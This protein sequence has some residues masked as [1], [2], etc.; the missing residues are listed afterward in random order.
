[1]RR[2]GW[3]RDEKKWKVKKWKEKAWSEEDKKCLTQRNLGE[4][5]KQKAK[6]NP[7]FFDAH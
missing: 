1:M 5:E 7:G 3:G 4:I 6:Q 2:A